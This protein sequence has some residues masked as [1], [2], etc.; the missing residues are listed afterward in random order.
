MVKT[1][2]PSV[3]GPT[4]CSSWETRSDLGAGVRFRS[5]ICYLEGVQLPVDRNR[6]NRLYRHLHLEDTTVIGPA[7]WPPLGISKYVFKKRI[8]K[9][10]MK[11]TC[12]KIPTNPDE[13]EYYGTSGSMP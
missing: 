1:R 13:L 4:S 10:N 8:R 11:E 9:I 5:R 12:E 6:R 2:N 3:V 7:F